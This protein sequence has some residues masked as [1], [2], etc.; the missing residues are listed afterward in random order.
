MVSSKLVA[1]GKMACTKT[2]EHSTGGGKTLECESGQFTSA[3]EG[4]E[5][6]KGAC[7]RHEGVHR[8]L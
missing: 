2:R 4:E 8:L 1:S 6:L 3:E 7:E 5:T